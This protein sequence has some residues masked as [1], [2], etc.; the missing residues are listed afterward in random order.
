MTRVRT[1]LTR[2]SVSCVLLAIILYSLWRVPSA[3]TSTCSVR[4][5][6]LPGI[7]VA[8]AEPFSPVSV[9]LVRDG[10]SFR[11]ED[12]EKSSTQGLIDA[13]NKNPDDIIRASLQYERHANGLY[14]VTSFRDEYTVTLRPFRSTPLS[15]DESARARA[16]FVGWL[17]SKNGGNMPGVAE[18]LSPVTPPRLILNWSG[19]ANSALALIGWALFALSLGWVSPAVRSWRRRRHDL[20]LRNGRCPRCGYSIYGI[21]T[22]ICPECGK[23]L[24]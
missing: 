13:M 8:K 15:S 12:L 11:V 22:G 16:A 14:D 19:I 17:A 21:S 24:T 5:W 10:A 3:D 9:F 18:A 6:T 4:G 2:P 1:F 7:L 23:L 20:A